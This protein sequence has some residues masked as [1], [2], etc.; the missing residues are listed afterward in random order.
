MEILMYMCIRMRV[1]V[2]MFIS[3]SNQIMHEKILKFINISQVSQK[4][5]KQENT[6]NASCESVFFIEMIYYNEL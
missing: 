4:L 5:S 3:Q 2:H 6:K 1:C